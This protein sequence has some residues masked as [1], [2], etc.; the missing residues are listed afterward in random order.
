MWGTEG[1]KSGGAFFVPL[2]IGAGLRYHVMALIPAAAGAGGAG[3]EKQ[4]ERH[5]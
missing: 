3:N 2:R 5:G 4:D 1:W